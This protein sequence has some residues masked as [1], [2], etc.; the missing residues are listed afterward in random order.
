MKHLF[1]ALFLAL[2]VTAVSQGKQETAI[3][4]LLQQQT[5]SWNAGNL[6]AFMQT[7]WQSDS[8]MF[9]GKKGVVWGWQQTLENYKKG[10]PD[11]AAMGTLSFHIIQLKKLSRKYY[12]VVGQW[13]LQREKDAPAGHY[14]LLLRK[15][16]GAWKIVSDHSS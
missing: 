11:Q 3:R 9:I 12:Q 16:R 15:I 2:S 10:Y 8:L 4:K 7:Y 14:T 5:A 1:L 6:E 13:M